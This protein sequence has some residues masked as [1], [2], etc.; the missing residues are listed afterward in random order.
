MPGLF[1][2]LA[3]TNRA[4]NA[5]TAGL[6]TVGQNIANVNTAGYTRRTIDLAEVAPTDNF[7]SGA[8]VTVQGVHSNRDT[9]TEQRLWLEQPRQQQQSAMSDLIGIAQSAIGLPGA[10][11]DQTLGSFFDSFGSLAQDPTSATARQTVVLQGQTVSDG[12]HQLSTALDAVA[13]D[14]DTRVRTAVQDISRY[15]TQIAAYNGSL[16]SVG[17]P[18]T[19]QGA[20]VVDNL[21]QA[22]N[23]LSGVAG[24][25]VTQRTDG[26]LDVSFADGH[27]LVVGDTTYLPSVAAAAPSGYAAVQAADGTD[28]TSQLTTG[29][30]GGLLQV[31]DTIIPGYKNQLDTLAYTLTQQVNALHTGGYDLNGTAGG[32]F[33]TPLASAAGAAAAIDVGAAVA[34]DP[35]KVAA[36]GSAVAGDNQTAR[37]IANLSDAKVVGGSATFAQGWG[38]LVYQVGLDSQTATEQQTTS[39]AIVSQLASLRD[40]TSGVSI[41]EEAT[42][43]LKFQRAYQANARYFTAVNGAIDTLLQMVGV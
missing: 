6:E 23:N 35:S 36:A 2:S 34:A 12:F 14:A 15:A 43:M 10:S 1:D 41:D 5:Q 18:S 27:A 26:Q 9:F 17:G 20:V 11:L 22:V 13:G 42:M 4:L 19:S 8:G 7:S 40:S 28:I 32:D 21:R 25:T 16:A 31:R 38:D 39:S 29:T 33:F 37:A 3:A 24:I 30:I